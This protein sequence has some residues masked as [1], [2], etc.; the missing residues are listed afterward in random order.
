MPSCHL[1]G[2]RKEPGSE[3]EGETE[4]EERERKNPGQRKMKHIGKK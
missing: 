4:K 3:G 1:D 2:I